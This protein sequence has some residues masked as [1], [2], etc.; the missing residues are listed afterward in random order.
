MIARIRG[1]LISS[2]NI[3]AVVDVNGVGYRML[4]P[5]SA[6]TVLPPI[7]DEVMFVTHL[8]VREDELT[9]YGF[10]DDTERKLFELLL[11]VSGVGPRAALNLLSTFG[12]ESLVHLIAG[13][14]TRAIMKAPG[15]GAKTAQRI[16][17]DLKERAIEMSLLSRFDKQSHGRMVVAPSDDAITA[18]VGL[19]YHRQDARVAV[20]HA[21]ATEVPPQDAGGI[22]KL[23]L[24]LLTS[25]QS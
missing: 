7:G 20:E 3:S 4:L 18:L 1:E 23:A 10:S 2:D 11:T 24:Q 22:I 9:L 6:L 17:I 12:A 13:D 14:D 25:S 15:I 21:L 8:H 19:G 16:V 5:E